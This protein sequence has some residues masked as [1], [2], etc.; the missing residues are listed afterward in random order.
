[1]EVVVGVAVA[2]EA[3]EVVDSLLVALLSSTC[4]QASVHPCI[5]DQ[6]STP[7]CLQGVWEV[8]EE[9]DHPTLGLAYLHSS[10]MDR[11]GTHSTVLRYLVVEAQ[12]G[13]CLPWEEAW[14]RG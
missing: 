1:M 11:V 3:E 13:H 6:D 8:L 10:S 12:E 9:G 5:P 4:H 7:C 14:A 2:G